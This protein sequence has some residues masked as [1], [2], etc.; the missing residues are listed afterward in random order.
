MRVS[1]ASTGGAGAGGDAGFARSRRARYSSTGST[2]HPSGE[3]VCAAAPAAAI[4]HTTIA[5]DTTA[6]RS[7]RG[8]LGA[9]GGRARSGR[10]SYDDDRVQAAHHAR[11]PRKIRES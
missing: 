4:V 7:M 11:R 5:A 8:L 3:T 10:H 9:V 2:T 1:V 6:V